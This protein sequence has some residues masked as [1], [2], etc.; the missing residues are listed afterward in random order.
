[1]CKIEFF[2]NE[3]EINPI[4][5]VKKALFIIY[6]CIEFFHKIKFYL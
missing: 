1:M 4:I 3:N 2:M 5:N 6:Q